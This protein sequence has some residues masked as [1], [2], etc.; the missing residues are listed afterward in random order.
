LV[1]HLIL[2]YV[3]APFTVVFYMNWF[4]TNPAFTPRKMLPACQAG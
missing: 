1:D 2:P 4:N 3:K